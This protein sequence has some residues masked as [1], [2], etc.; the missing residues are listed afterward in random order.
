MTP[1]VLLLVL[2]QA[3]AG[4]GPSAGA[5]TAPPLDD[6]TAFSVA[7][8]QL[9]LGVLAVEYGITDWLSIG[10]DPPAWAA[11]TV[12]PVFVP[13]LHL[14]LAFVR[15]PRWRLSGTVAGYYAHLDRASGLD[16]HLV[17]AP[18]ALFASAA[19]PWR[20]WI[21]LEGSYNLVRAF[22]NGDSDRAEV[23][24]TVATRAVQLGAMLE[25]RL[26]PRLAL[27]LRGRLQLMTNP[28]VLEG[29]ADFDPYTH[30]E[31][32]AEL[33][34][35]REHPWAVVAAATYQWRYV[36]LRLGVGYGSYFLPGANVTAP[37]FGIIPDGS[38]AFVF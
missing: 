22:G 16:G 33:A 8:G 2:Q 19:L 1:L 30:A 36:H 6:H 26:R 20:S 5:R 23:A 25:H 15:T 4:A 29:D 38:L 31:F 3:A 37:Y 34:P 14:E 7:G 21:H 27:T 9:K 10:T 32:A 28:L 13:N 35:A 17:A 18:L 12:S 11:R 24:G